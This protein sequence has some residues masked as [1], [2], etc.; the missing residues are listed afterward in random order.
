MKGFVRRKVIQ[1]LRRF[2]HE[3]CQEH[4]SVIYEEVENG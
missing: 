4:V 1:H 3:K 2:I